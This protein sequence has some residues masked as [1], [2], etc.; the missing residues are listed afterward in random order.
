MVHTKVE[1]CTSA[2]THAQTFDFMSWTAEGQPGHSLRQD[3]C[4]TF[5]LSKRK[6]DTQRGSTKQATAY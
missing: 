2:T 4:L 6:K 5:A 3:S 1:L